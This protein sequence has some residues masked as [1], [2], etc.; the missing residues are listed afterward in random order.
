MAEFLWQNER[1]VYL[2]VKVPREI[3]SQELERFGGDR[4]H[5]LRNFRLRWETLCGLIA[6]N[7]ARSSASSAPGTSRLY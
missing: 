3:F 1:F 4:T 6:S 5:T 7:P 2:R